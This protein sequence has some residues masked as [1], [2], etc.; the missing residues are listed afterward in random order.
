MISKSYQ[1][2]NNSKFFLENNCILFYGENLGLKKDYKKIIKNLENKAAII[3]LEQ[4]EILKNENILINEIN[5]LSLFSEKKVIFIEKSSDKILDILLKIDDQILETKVILFAD[6]LEKKSKLR[7]Y[8]EKSK[9]FQT[10]ACYQDNE[11]SLRKIVNN[12]L[13]GFQNLSLE[14]INL[15][16]EKCNSDRAK[17]YNEID[18]ILIFFQD[19]ILQSKK[20]EALLNLNVNEDF[21]SLKDQAFLGNKINTNRLLSDTNLENE[22]IT[23][24]LSQIN[25]RLT[26]LKEIK[27][28]AQNSNYENAINLI[29]PPIFWKDKTNILN[30]LK[31]WNLNKIN[32]ISKKTYET[33][34]KVKSNFTGNKNI[35]L[36]NLIVEICNQANA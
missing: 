20:L 24:Y 1:I 33:E 4:D 22:K 7:N 17:L 28:N 26:N 15:I 11:I 14:N 23:Y 34:I 27:D 8:F 2:E 12:K 18:K 13:K 6:I 35:L 19:K 25:N 32:T 29:K 31:K 5:N 3:N 16:L 10:V 36:K 9:T 21:S 30:Q